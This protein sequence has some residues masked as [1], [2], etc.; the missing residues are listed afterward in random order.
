MDNILPKHL[1]GIDKK[2]KVL[3]LGCGNDFFGTVRMDIAKSKSTTVIGDI[4]KKL[5][6]KKNEFDTIYTQFLFEHLINPNLVLKEVYRI[7][8]KNG[9]LI[10]ITDNAGFW[11]FHTGKYT[12]TLGTIHYGG[13]RSDDD[14][15]MH[16]AL[17][18]P[19]HIRNHLEK[20]GFKIKKIEYQAY[21]EIRK[22]GSLKYIIAKIIDSFLNIVGLPQISGYSIYAEGVKE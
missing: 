22:R 16:Y 2:K 1:E 13:Y 19:E 20:A 12:K 17:Y 11:G 21:G 14:D 15:D 6:F 4:E 8:K 9:V 10:L 3:N 18:T 7:L 5:P